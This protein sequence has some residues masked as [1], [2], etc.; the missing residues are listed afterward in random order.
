MRDEPNAGLR[1]PRARSRR[2]HKGCRS[3]RTAGRWS[4]KSKSAKECVKTHLPNGPAPKMDGA[5]ACRL[6]PAVEANFFQTG[7]T[8][9]RARSSVKKPLGVILG[10]TGSGA[11]LGGS[12]EYSN[13]SFEG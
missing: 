10:R 4:W 8:S 6:Y 5:E 7:S 11:D 1:R 13:E 2:P 3:I 12:S 9:R